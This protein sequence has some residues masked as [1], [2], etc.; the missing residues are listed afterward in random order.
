MGAFLS[1]LVFLVI[2]LSDH[3]SFLTQ[4]ASPRWPNALHFP[5]VTWEYEGHQPVLLRRRGKI[6]LSRG[7]RNGSVFSI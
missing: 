1:L 4:V 2:S 6:R 7:Q 3:L 5:S